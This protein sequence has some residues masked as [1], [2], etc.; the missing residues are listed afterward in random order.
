MKPLEKEIIS[1]LRIIEKSLKS[2]PEHEL[3]TSW[4][5][6]QESL[7]LCENEIK[8]RDI[9]ISRGTAYENKE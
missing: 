6:L 5:M 2:M 7:I 4:L 3:K 1:Q 8:R 9:N